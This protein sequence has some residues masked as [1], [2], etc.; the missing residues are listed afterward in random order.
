MDRQEAVREIYRIDDANVAL[1]WVSELADS[2]TDVTYAP[3]IR[4]LG[5]TLRQWAPQIAAWHRSRASNGPTEAANNLAKRIKRVAFG[6]TNFVHWRVRVLLYAGGPDWTKLP[7]I[8]P[9]TP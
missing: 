8:F 4:Q 3:E 9:A 6:M 1:E 2:M 7:A 5:R